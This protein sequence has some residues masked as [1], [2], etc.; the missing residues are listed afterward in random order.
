[1]LKFLLLYPVINFILANTLITKYS[2]TFDK[3]LGSLYK[4]LKIGLN[5]L[6]IPPLF[7]DKLGKFGRAQSYN[8]RL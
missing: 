2:P 4:I 6:T 7:K 8:R 3:F 1:M 5:P